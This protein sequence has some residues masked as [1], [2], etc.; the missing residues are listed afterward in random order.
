MHYC[1][2][3]LESVSVFFNLGCDDHEE[4]I[5]L[6]SCC[7]KSATTHCD[8]QGSNCCDDEVK[9]INQDFTSLL[10]LFGKW[11]D[12]V[13]EVTL[14]PTQIFTTPDVAKAMMGPAYAGSDS[15]PPIYIKYHSLIF[16]A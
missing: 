15:G 5:E 9:F 6:A 16:Y 3:V 8:T 13:A 14:N 10:P 4:V 7:Q 11:M 12:L 1:K 2:G